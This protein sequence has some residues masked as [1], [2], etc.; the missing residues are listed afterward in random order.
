VL[1]PLPTDQGA[2]FGLQFFE[3]DAHISSRIM[4]VDG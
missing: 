3:C 4:V 2:E 1:V